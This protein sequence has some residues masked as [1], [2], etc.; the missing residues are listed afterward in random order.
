MIRAPLMAMSLA[1]AAPCADAQS[2]RDEWCP[3]GPGPITYLD[4]FGVGFGDHIT[5]EV[6]TLPPETDPVYA[7]ALTCTRN[8]PTGEIDAS[9][10]EVIHS[11][12]VPDLAWLVALLLPDDRLAIYL[13]VNNQT[14]ILSRCNF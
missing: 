14:Q 8:Q 3:E 2:I 4:E 9:G 6:N 5:C 12:P 13:D 10:N 7:V 1:L 11:Q